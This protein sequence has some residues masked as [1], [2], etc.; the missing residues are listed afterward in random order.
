MILVTDGL[1]SG[2]TDIDREFG[3]SVRELRGK[4][5]NLIAIGIGSRAIKKTVKNARVIN[6]PTD[7]AKQFMDVYMSQSA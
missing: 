1:P 2:Y 7:I 6:K 5:I 4:G 3:I